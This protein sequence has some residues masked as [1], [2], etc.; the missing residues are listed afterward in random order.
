MIVA[1]TVATQESDLNGPP[2]NRRIFLLS[3]ANLGGIR[4]GYLLGTNSK[5]DLGRQLRAGGVMLGELFSFISGLYFRGKLAYA[6]AFSAPPVDVPGCF[7]ITAT[8][9]LLTPESLITL[10]QLREFAAGNIDVDDRT[11]R[12]LVERDSRLLAG[13][14]GERCEIVLLGSIAAPKYVEALLPIFHE[15]LLFPAEFVGRGDMS[16]GGLML[17]AVEASQELAYVPVLSATRHGQKPPKL[18]PIKLRDAKP[19]RQPLP[20][21]R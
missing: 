16:R 2:S 12:V 5:S 8:A 9:G 17:R 18:S 1:N 7:I 4:A 20:K 14:L 13:R 15:R 3:P 19:A 11:Y 10:E 6:R 21:S